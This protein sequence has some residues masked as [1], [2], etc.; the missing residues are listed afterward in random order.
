MYIWKLNLALARNFLNFLGF[1]V[2]LE[3]L[4]T[5]SLGEFLVFSGNPKVAKCYLRNNILTDIFSMSSHSFPCLFHVFHVYFLFSMSFPCLPCLPCLRSHPAIAHM[6]I[7]RNW[8]SI[9]DRRESYLVL[10]EGI[11][12]K[13]CSA[14]IPNPCEKTS[15]NHRHKSWLQTS[16]CTYIKVYGIEPGPWRGKQAKYQ[17]Y[18]HIMEICGKWRTK[19]KGITGIVPWRFY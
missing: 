13:N 1:L 12:K 10:C 18:H 3:C 7:F 11:V 8:T 15:A 6:P 14:A 4:K 16:S 5:T 19:K 17:L 2:L 9:L